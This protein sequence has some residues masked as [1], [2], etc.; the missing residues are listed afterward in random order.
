MY[1]YSMSQAEMAAANP[2]MLFLCDD[3]FARGRALANKH[4]TINFPLFKASHRA[5][6]LVKEWEVYSHHEVKISHKQSQNLK[7]NK[8]TN[9]SCRNSA[10]YLGFIV[11][12]N[13]FKLINKQ[14]S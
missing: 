13:S 14:Q 12:E 8:Q 2:V 5:K 9:K 4:R 6:S 11:R 3:R 7:T 1:V 10:Q